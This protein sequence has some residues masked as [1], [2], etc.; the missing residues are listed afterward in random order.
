MP[1]L[2]ALVV[3]AWATVLAVALCLVV[4]PFLLGRA[5]FLLLHLPPEWTHDTA[6]FS[7]GLTVLKVGNS[8]YRL[9]T[10]RGRRKWRLGAGGERGKTHLV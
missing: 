6:S 10:N 1:L 8:R 2:T 7:V 9:F 5:V 4:L 3:A